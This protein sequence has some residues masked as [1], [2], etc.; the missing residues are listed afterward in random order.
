MRMISVSVDVGGRVRVVA[1]RLIACPLF[2]L[3]GAMLDGRRV[4]RRVTAEPLQ[5]AAPF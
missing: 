4:T 3:S 1:L 2:A 5:L